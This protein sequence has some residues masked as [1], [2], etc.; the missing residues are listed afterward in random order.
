MTVPADVSV[1]P[2]P[3]RTLLPDAGDDARAI[4]MLCAD[5]RTESG[6]RPLVLDEYNRVAHWLQRHSLRP[7]DLLTPEG[8]DALASFPGHHALR[9]ERLQALMTGE[10]DLAAGL[11]AWRDAGG[12]VRARTDPAYPA[13]LRHDLR[14]RAPAVLYGLGEPSLLERGSLG[15]VGAST[16]DDAALAF[17]ERTVERC[18]G[19][20][21]PIVIGGRDGI[22]RPV[23]DQARDHRA[24]VI[25]VLPAGIGTAADRSAVR[26]S[27]DAGR[28]VLVSSVAPGARHAPSRPG[29]RLL[30]AVANGVLLV[31]ARERT[32]RAWSA[33]M[34][35]L[36]RAGHGDHRAETLLVRAEAPLPT[37][38]RLLIEAGAR[39]FSRRMLRSTRHLL[40][41]LRG[42]VDVDGHR[43]MSAEDIEQLAGEAA[44]VFPRVWPSLRRLL[45]E[46][47][48][49]RDVRDALADIRLSQ[50]RDWLLTAVDR[51]LAIR[52]ERPV[53]YHLP[54]TEP[55]GEE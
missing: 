23:V 52:T 35:H 5:L 16:A 14:H 18:A 36:Q 10:A 20:G 40:D 54:A 6:P 11:Q 33:A 24:S 30:Y 19:D 3:L 22:T 49:A 47:R 48:S 45:T 50:A 42:P 53:R 29:Q 43:D 26:A 4:L 15:I 51:G 44:E 25:G 12:W 27:V 28:M 13:Q 34:D 2:A 55:A 37:G 41:W 38:N 21:I 9:P 32:G 8:R 39:P 1:A 31:Q 46:P 17:C 7:A